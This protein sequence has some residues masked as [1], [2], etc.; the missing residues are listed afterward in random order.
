MKKT[1]EKKAAAGIRARDRSILAALQEAGKLS[2]RKLAELRGIGKDS[3]WRALKAIE[4]KQVHPESVLWES[5]VAQQWLRRMYQAAILTFV[6][7]GGVGAERVSVFLHRARLEKEIASSPTALRTRLKEV[8][9]L[10]ALYGKIQEQ[11]QK[12]KLKHLV[13]GGDETFFHGLLI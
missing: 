1:N 3:V 4:R 10:L 2:L 5:E 11:A 6:L 8:E 13:A 7:E 12:G 9:E